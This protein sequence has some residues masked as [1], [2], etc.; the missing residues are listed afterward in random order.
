[1]WLAITDPAL[2]SPERW[3]ARSLEL[4]RSGEADRLLLRCKALPREDQREAA[5]LLAD[6]CR[7]GDT[8]LL[9]HNDLDLALEV[10]AWGLH[11]PA[12]APSPPKLPTTLRKSRSCHTEQELA[13]AQ[14][15]GFDFALYSPIFSPLSKQ[16]AR[17]PLGL[18][19]LARACARFSVPIFAL[20][21]VTRDHAPACLAA[22]ASGVASISAFF[23]E[24]R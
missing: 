2:P 12:D 19:A 10:G 3:L 16:D 7:E 11:L 24:D 5:R 4:A 1:V 6:A 17:P 15:E 20:G 21:G 22:G 23:Q 18:G 8:K 13:R 14:A 9:V